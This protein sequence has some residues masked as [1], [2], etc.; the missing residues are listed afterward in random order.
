[1]QQEGIKPNYATDFIVTDETVEGLEHGFVPKVNLT[2]RYSDDD[3][4]YFTYSH[5]LSQ[6]WRKCSKTQIQSS[7]FI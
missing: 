6:W 3:M 5:R 1:M 4:V 2:W 7:Q